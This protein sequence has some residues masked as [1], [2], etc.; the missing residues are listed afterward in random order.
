MQAREVLQDESNVQP[1]VCSQNAVDGRGKG[2]QA[3]DICLEMPSNSL[4]RHTRTIPRSDGAVQ[5]WGP[6]P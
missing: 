1:V 2:S 6:E 3:N 5:D 4:R